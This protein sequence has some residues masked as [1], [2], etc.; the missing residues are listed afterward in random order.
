MTVPGLDLPRLRHFFEATVPGVGRLRAELIAGGRSNL[1]YRVTDGRTSW[2]LRRPP[3]GELTPSAHDMGREYRV[4]DALYGSGVPVARAVVLCEDPSVVG[5]PFSVVE[6]VVGRVLRTD[7][8]LADLSDHDV[9]RAAGALVDVIATLHAVDP[10]AVGLADLGRPR[11]YLSRQIRRW[12]GQWHLVATRELPDLERLHVLLAERCP[13][14]RDVAIVH[15]DPRIDN[16]IV[17][18]AEPGE[19][20]ALVDWEM[21]TLGDPLADLALHVV[22]RDPAFAPVLG[23]AGASTS[24]RMP[25][26]EWL[27]ERYATTSGRDI[28]DLD[29]H[30][31]L[32]YFKSAVIAEGIH[33]RHTAGHT[34][35]DGFGS[36]GHAVPRLVAAGLERLRVPRR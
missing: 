21:A 17:S 11:G 22:Y 34:V 12:N 28:V 30:L 23:G 14:E 1:T 27:V 18:P 31:A 29:F 10:A 25:A 15:G 3:L 35:G 24:H 16:A 9:E 13:D 36:V 33:A 4:V 26:S 2:V 19:V 8:D 32:A 7:D 5:A 20:R 6:F